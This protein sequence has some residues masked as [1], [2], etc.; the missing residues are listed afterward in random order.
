[1]IEAIVRRYRTGHLAGSA[2]EFR[3]AANRVETHDRWAAD[4][5]SDRLVTEVSADADAAGELDWW[6]RWTPRSTGRTS[7]RPVPAGNT[8]WNQ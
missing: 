3:S 2:W 6:S 7:S 4:G 5:T 8:N 1:M